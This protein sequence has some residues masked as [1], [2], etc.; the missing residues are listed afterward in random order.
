MQWPA[1]TKSFNRKTKCK[2]SAQFVALSL[3]LSE[4]KEAQRKK[5]Q[6]KERHRQE[7]SI[8]NAMVVWNNEILPHWD[9]TYVSTARRVCARELVCA[10][11]VLST[12]FVCRKGTRR[13][14]ELWWQGL[15]PSVRGRVWSLA[16]GNELNIT[17][18]TNR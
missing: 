18:G 10:A 8:S 14:R 2:Q 12:V 6:M 15:P 17:P 16:I 4:M 13:V 3:S 9:T 1:G 5:R 7:D 11:L